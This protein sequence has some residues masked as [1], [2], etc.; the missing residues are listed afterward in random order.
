M[1]HEP[2]WKYLLN[3]NEV[4]FRVQK[5]LLSVFW[6]YSLSSVNIASDWLRAKSSPLDEEEKKKMDDGVD[7]SLASEGNYL[8]VDLWEAQPGL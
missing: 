1:L 5:A 7:T 4:T 2:S 3:C 6:E 8:F